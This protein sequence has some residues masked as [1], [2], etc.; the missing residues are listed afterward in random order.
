MNFRRACAQRISFVQPSTLGLEKDK[1]CADQQHNNPESKPSAL[2]VW[3]DFIDQPGKFNE[4]LAHV[5]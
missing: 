2:G 4:K 1:A 3:P 5:F